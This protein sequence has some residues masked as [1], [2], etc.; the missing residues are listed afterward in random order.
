MCAPAVEYYSNL[1][2]LHQ[3][4]ML[5]VI[6]EAPEGILRAE[7]TGGLLG[8]FFLMVRPGNVL[9]YCRANRLLVLYP[10]KL[11]KPE[12]KSTLLLGQ[13]FSIFVPV[14]HLLLFLMVI[15][16]LRDFHRLKDLLVRPQGKTLT[17]DHFI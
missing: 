15:F 13:L 9:I 14:K 16:V 6:A 3:Y 11:K 1:I 12:N 2:G 8:F 10:V 17:S 5:A 7:H 4:L